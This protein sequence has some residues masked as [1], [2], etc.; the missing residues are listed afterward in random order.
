MVPPNCLPA[1]VCVWYALCAMDWRL[2]ELSRNVHEL[3][4]SG[5][6]A[7][8][9]AWVLL[10]S[11]VHFDNPDC[12]R[13]LLKRHFD[14]AVERGAPII[15]AGDWFCAMQGLKDK[16]RSRPKIRKEDAD[17]D[18][19][20]CLVESTVQWLMPYRH[21]LVVMGYGNH[22]TSILRH[23][24]TDLIKRTCKELQREGGKTRA[25]GYAGW[26]KFLMSRSNQKYKRN[27]YYFHGT[28]GGAPVT[29]GLIQYSRLA[30]G[31]E[32]D[33]YLSGHIHQRLHAEVQ[34]TY[35]NRNGNIKRR[36]VDY[37]RSSC[38]KDEYQDGHG[39]FQT[40][41]GSMARPMGGYWL[42]WYM[43]PAGRGQ[44]RLARELI[45]TD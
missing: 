26:V 43:R 39:G 13:S 24:E 36:R 5:L 44:M 31:V 3:R 22:E 8:W 11:D 35:L 28:G 2:A 9:E 4:Y 37:V 16:R 45:S 6:A 25:G 21:N 29:L 1:V 7:G 42:R 40:E 34:R 12:D 14:Q 27:L 38:Y 19:F 33:I 23:Q 10:V 30:V 17:T 20:D 15:C 18:Y 32:A 41:Q